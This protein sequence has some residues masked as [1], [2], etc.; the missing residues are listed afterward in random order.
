MHHCE[1]IALSVAISRV[2]LPGLCAG[3]RLCT[4]TYLIH[5]ALNAFVVRLGLLQG[6]IL[7]E[8]AEKS[9]YVDTRDQLVPIRE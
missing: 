6:Y 2:S 5:T 3:V 4:M 8:H 1:V 7:L 9:V